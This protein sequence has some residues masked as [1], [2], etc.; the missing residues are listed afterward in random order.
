MLKAAQSTLAQDGTAQ[1]TR[2]ACASATCLPFPS[3]SFSVITCALATHHMDVAAALAEMRRVLRSG[4]HLLLLDVGALPVWRTA[5]GRAAIHWALLLYGWA[6]RSNRAKA[7]AGA[8]PNLRTT[9]EWQS[10]LRNSG[11]VHVE[12][13]HTWAPRRMWYPQALLYRAAA[14]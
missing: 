1:Q 14:A 7:E 12:L 6:H 9:E 11:F 8:V 2:L 13:V 5:V 10:L 3:G 4:G